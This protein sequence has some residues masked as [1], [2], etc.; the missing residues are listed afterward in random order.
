MPSTTHAR[1]T[2]TGV[3][4]AV[5]SSAAVAALVA[6]GIAV[7]P[8]RSAAAPVDDANGITSGEALALVAQHAPEWTTPPTKVPSS[9][10]TDAPLL[11]NGDVGV[12][13]GGTGDAQ[14]YYVGKNDFWTARTGSIAPVGRVSV[15]IPGLSGASYSTVQDISTAEVRGAFDLGSSQLRTT[16]WVDAH[17]N[18]LVTNLAYEGTSAQA[19]TVSPVPAD[20]NTTLGLSGTSGD[21]VWV[22]PT[23]DGA[24]PVTNVGR[25]QAG[26]GRYYFDGVI[27]DVRVYDRALTATEVGDLAAEI[28]V[29]TGLAHR[30]AY[31]SIPSNAYNA[32]LTS[33]Q[34]TPNAINFNGSSTYVDEGRIDTF[35]YTKWTIGAWIKADTLGAANY[36]LSQGEWNKSLSLGLSAGKLRVS[37]NG[38]YAQAPAAVPTGSW[39]YVT[40]VFDGSSL[41]AYVDGVQVAQTTP[42]QGTFSATRMATRVVGATPTISNSQLT[43]T[44]QPGNEY[45]IAT[46][47]LSD[48]DAGT[49][50]TDA[51]AA[52]SGLTATQ[53]TGY[54]NDHRNWW[55]DFWGKSYVEIPDKAI[56]GQW[57][58]SLYTLA[59]ASRPGQLAPGIWGPWITNRTPAW[60]GDYHFNYN[61]EMPFYAAY[62]T[63]HIELTENYD[64][65]ILDWIPRGQASAQLFGTQYGHSYDG[66]VYPV[67][68]SPTSL[69]SPNTS[70][71]FWSQKSNALFAAT[72]MVHRYYYTYDAAYADRVYGFLKEVAAFWED[73]LVW[74]SVN[75]RFVIERDSPNEKAE[76]TVWPQ[77]NSIVSMGFLRLLLAGVIDMSTDLGVDSSLR[78]TWQDMLDKLSALP[79]MERNGQTVFR[80]TE[81]GTSWLTSNSIQTLPIFP[82]NQA[83]KVA[84]ENAPNSSSADTLQVAYNTVA[85]RPAWNDINATSFYYPAAARV[86]IDPDTILA[87]LANSINTHA[88]NNFLF[89]AY[90]GGGIENVATTPQTLTEMMAQSFQG[91]IDVFANW[92]EDVDGRYGNLGAYGGFLVS[93][94]FEEG[95]VSYIRTISQQ[96][97]SAT[98]VNP[99]GGDVVVY[100]NGVNSGTVSGATFTLPTTAGEVIDLAPDG[101]SHAS[102]L[103]DLAAPLRTNVALGKIVTGYSSQFDA[104]SWKAANINDGIVTSTSRGWAS[105]AGAT[106]GRNE[107]VSI[108][109]G[110]AYT[111]SSFQIQNED[112]ADNR[113]IKDYVLYGSSTGAFAGEEFVITSGTIPA[114]PRMATHSVSFTPASARYVKIK[115][116]SSYSSYVIVGDLRLFGY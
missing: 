25:E 45:Q 29:T 112:A 103:T 48:L 114:L 115:G 63:N 84:S 81:V 79:T 22:D 27:D 42:V 59:S 86:G 55:N 60:L 111:L 89:P 31:D 93:S 82:G 39:V 104:S 36:I 5:L 73:Y 35:S 87:N 43:F 95:D 41:T 69:S 10:V 6:T 88:S 110:Q 76:G 13:V 8:E 94:K 99:W 108:D 61:Y 58:G 83:G 47:V 68:F 24:V 7:L 101:T 14:T 54:N 77:T 3:L 97:E 50:R 116:T 75:N 71:Q 17:R 19:V 64:K 49:F 2:Q 67:G 100:R 37:L 102:I 109:L 21:V 57:Y 30:F 26:G 11:G 78:A 52:V 53:I 92:P 16:S 46:A 80:L 40:G 106:T 85:Q 38:Q 20:G 105:V 91:Q 34:V 113:N 66:V 74:D 65:P 62:S 28:D 9:A 72:N 56:E 107:W 96:G 32:T 70:Y 90:W 23:S 51:I 12:V 44:M 15:S 1:T 33:G 4:R 98:F 18:L